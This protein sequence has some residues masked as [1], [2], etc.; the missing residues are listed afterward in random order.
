MDVKDAAQRVTEIRDDL[1]IFALQQLS[2]EKPQRRLQRATRTNR[3][4]SRR[5]STERNKVQVPRGISPRALDGT[6]D[7]CDQ[8]LTFQGSVSHSTTPELR[9]GISTIL[10]SKGVES[11]TSSVPFCDNNLREVLVHLYVTR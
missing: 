11:F 9:E 10:L 5:N 1:I 8:D 3:H 6:C 2:T 7:L 4:F